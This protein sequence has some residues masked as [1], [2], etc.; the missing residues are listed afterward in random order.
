[1]DV[2]EGATIWLSGAA[3]ATLAKWS[4]VAQT[5]VGLGLAASHPRR[6]VIIQ[7][8]ALRPPNSY[9]WE[10]L[11]V[12]IFGSCV[13][14]E[15]SHRNKHHE[16]FLTTAKDRL[17][18]VIREKTRPKK[19]TGLSLFDGT[20]FNCRVV[21]VWLASKAP[22]DLVRVIRQV[23]VPISSSYKLN[24]NSNSFLHN[25]PLGTHFETKTWGSGRSRP[26]R[27][28]KSQSPGP[29][30]FAPGRTRTAEFFMLGKLQN[31][32]SFFWFPAKTGAPSKRYTHWAHPEIQMQP[33]EGPH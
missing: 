27:P 28:S 9:L 4:L 20:L 24:Y 25:L 21:V 12:A 23:K 5:G 13:L 1:M 22:G 18:L 10:T 6:I 16:A 17:I 7:K 32:W 2:S 26:C 11:A 14:Q 31:A 19:T 15:Y 29:S 3:G 30:S 8:E 33:K